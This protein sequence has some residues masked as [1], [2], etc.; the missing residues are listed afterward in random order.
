[1]RKAYKKRKLN[2]GFTISEL[3]IATLIL[4][5][6]SGMLVTCIRLGMKQLYKQTAESEAQMLCTM[7]ST[8]VQDEL[9]Y[10]TLDAAETK[11]T[12]DG[13]FLAFSSDRLSGTVGGFYV[14]SET[15]DDNPENFD[16]EA[17]TDN[18]I[19]S[20]TNLGKLYLRNSDGSKK[21]G[22]VST[23]A[24]NINNSSDGSLQAGMQL[25]EKGNG[26]EVIIRVY[27]G[28][29]IT[30]PLAT[31]DFFVGF[32]EAD[33]E[34]DSG[35][36]DTGETTFTVTFDPNGGTFSDNS[37][38]LKVYSGFVSGSS[39][40]VPTVSHTSL[41]FDG[42]KPSVG[43]KVTGN[44][45]VVTKDE[46]YTAQWK[47]EGGTGGTAW[48]YGYGV[49]ISRIDPN[50]PSP[51]SVANVSLEY[52]SIIGGLSA[53]GD[54]QFWPAHPTDRPYDGIAAKVHRDGY[55]LDGWED[56]DGT[57]YYFAN[58]AHGDVWTCTRTSYFKPHYAK[59]Y[60]ASFYSGYDILGNPTGLITSIEV[61]YNTTLT[62]PNNPSKS[63]AVF[64]GWEY[65]RA[66][67][68]TDVLPTNT[69]SLAYTFE[70][71]MDFVATWDSYTLTFY[72]GTEYNATIYCDVDGNFVSK[73][74][75][76][77]VEPP[78]GDS[79]TWV[80]DGWYSFDGTTP[81]KQYNGDGSVASTNTIASLFASGVKNVDLY[82]RW[83]NQKAIYIKTDVLSTAGSFL[84]IGGDSIG[85]NRK[86]M[87][88]NGEDVETANVTVKGSANEM[89]VAGS[90]GTNYAWRAQDG[91]DGRFHIM[92][93]GNYLDINQSWGLWYN[94][95]MR[96]DDDGRQWSYDSSKH[97]LSAKWRNN[98]RYVSFTGSVFENDRRSSNEGN[99][100]IYEYRAPGD[101]FTFNGYTP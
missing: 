83:T 22:L 30:T 58:N 10:A 85:I 62:F 45:V 9:T 101:A 5:L 42:W 18:E 36:V 16:F 43:E 24:Y 25:I 60:T 81:I 38:A 79:D 88:D 89:Y 37:T 46:T 55:V 20:K 54:T 76:D 97:E 67:D 51:G 61:P 28:T 87:T 15:T 93:N 4:L 69:T 2:S 48:F 11:D 49:D 29:D 80:L 96:D 14:A 32:S 71:D 56:Q 53:H 26:Y 94:L 41:T 23:G 8:V 52:G 33:M 63:D 75:S 19:Y 13:K 1:M 40:P 95:R 35:G 27:N 7:L 92:K 78:Y 68:E 74:G 99:V 21:Y 66:Q 47:N 72:N 44:S 100:H 12:E 84:I 3:L 86:A 59:I 50:N 73:E 70:K 98:T 34:V 90:A 91:D 31:K 6:A 17:V 39:V 65:E 64:M 57:V 82:A 77:V